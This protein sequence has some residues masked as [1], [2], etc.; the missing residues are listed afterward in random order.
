MEAGDPVTS[1]IK[2]VRLL[3]HGSMGSIWVADHAGLGTQVA[4]KF[5]TPEIAQNPHLVTRFSHEA[6]AA[7][8]IR[9]PHVVQVFDHGVAPDGSPY[10][11][12][13]LLDGESLQKRLRRDG[14]LDP[15]LTV[16]IVAQT[17]KALSRAHPLGI[18]HR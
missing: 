17:C 12:M 3:D 11:V 18:V 1:T 6:H 15:A 9:S 7:A 10:I 2:L 16:A 13:E 8:Q 5:M 4:V 14:R